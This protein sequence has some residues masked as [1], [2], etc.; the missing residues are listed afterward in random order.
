[1]ISPHGNPI[2]VTGLER[3][4]CDVLRS[5]NQIDIQLVYEALKRYENKKE[6]IWI[7]FLPTPNAS[8]FKKL[9]GSVSKFSY[10]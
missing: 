3:T 4:I 5:R 9:F 7:Y 8:E 10:E 6:K 1:M 2:R